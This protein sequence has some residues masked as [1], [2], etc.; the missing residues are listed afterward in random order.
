MRK[1]LNLKFLW[2]GD[3]PVVVFLIVLDAFL[4]V[5]AQNYYSSVNDLSTSTIFR[6]PASQVDFK[7]E[8]FQKL[9]SQGSWSAFENARREELARYLQTH[10]RPKPGNALYFFPE[11]LPEKSF[12]KNFAV[13]ILQPSLSSLKK[14][15]DEKS[16]T[17]IHSAFQSLRSRVINFEL[18]AASNVED[19]SDEAKDFL[20]LYEEF[21]K[22]NQ[23]KSNLKLD[24]R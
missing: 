3:R 13:Q 9:A 6:R 8:V 2:K 23:E 11:T 24:S 4:L 20:G 22:F 21:S 15:C 16:P 10:T 12:E 14:A 17:G 5:L 7:V 18:G 1:H 19:L